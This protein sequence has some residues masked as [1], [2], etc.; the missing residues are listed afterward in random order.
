MQG[1]A[2]PVL[3]P[4]PSS[5]ASRR[6]PATWADTTAPKR[7]APLPANDPWS[8]VNH[9]KKRHKAAPWKGKDRAADRVPEQTGGRFGRDGGGRG[10]SN[11]GRSMATTAEAGKSTSHSGMY[12]RP[13]PKLASA[14]AND[15]PGRTPS[16]AHMPTTTARPVPL[17]VVPE[18][19]TAPRRLPHPTRGPAPLEDLF[20]EDIFVKPPSRSS[21]LAPDKPAEP[22]PA[23]LS[24]SHSAK[25][26]FLPRETKLKPLFPKAVC[27]TG[28]NLP[29]RPKSPAQFVPVE[30]S[31]EAVHK[32]ALDVKERFRSAVE[33]SAGLK[34]G[35]APAVAPPSPSLRRAEPTRAPTPEKKCVAAS[36]ELFE[37][38]PVSGSPVD[39]ARDEAED[40]DISDAESAGPPVPK[41][42]RCRSDGAP[43]TGV[44]ASSR[45][46]S[47]SLSSSAAVKRKDRGTK[48]LTT[49]VKSERPRRRF[50]FPYKD[51]GA[52]V[53]DGEVV[54]VRRSA[55]ATATRY[56]AEAA[57]TRTGRKA[58][59][60]AKTTLSSQLK[61]AKPA[62]LGMQRSF[63][64]VNEGT[65]KDWYDIDCAEMIPA[66]PDV[67][68]RKGRSS[69]TADGSEGRDLRV[70]IASLTLSPATYTR[71]TSVGDHRVVSVVVQVTKSEAGGG[72]RL[73]RRTRREV[74]LQPPTPAPSDSSDG[75]QHI[76]VAEEAFAQISV[77][78]D[79]ATVSDLHSLSLTV[80]LELAAEAGVSHSAAYPLASLLSAQQPSQLDLAGA[81]GE[82]GYL[83]FDVALSRT[84][85]S[86]DRTGTVDALA[87][88]VEAIALHEQFPDGVWIPDPVPIRGHE[89]PHEIDL[90]PTV[91]G[92]LAFDLMTRVPYNPGDPVP[93]LA[94]ETSESMRSFIREADA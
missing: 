20:G 88:R 65:E 53:D 38:V 87:A 79:A 78:L 48:S 85:P 54:A 11:I 7:T 4:R 25:K 64:A 1:S 43:R 75:L 18:I 44:C 92:K 42:R 59:R 29:S 66:R 70:A 24:S 81:A 63:V 60:Q 26:L 39:I 5:S 51:L 83:D 31:N 13:T 32:A 57:S 41:R 40:A 61:R 80:S 14:E 30:A 49:S 15:R 45:S 17:R 58:V 56:P 93:F 34:I 47:A 91:P 19:G 69:E 28:S 23:T 68:L 73:L 77:R 12:T 2:A 10:S 72:D 27:S 94:D 36:P 46:G 67:P 3:P 84:P 21:S 55:A 76:A 90:P 9:D 62:L 52:I 50:S 16:Q 74:L 6:L 8:A 22:A 35:L 86:P 33:R 82:L 37:G 89:V 71:L